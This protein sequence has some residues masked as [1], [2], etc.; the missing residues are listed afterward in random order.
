MVFCI[1]VEDLKKRNWEIFLI[2]HNL[3]K[4]YQGLTIPN[5]E[6]LRNVKSSK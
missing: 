4:H 3:V 5:N 6:K 2:C 1:K